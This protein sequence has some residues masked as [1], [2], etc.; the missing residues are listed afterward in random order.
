MIT[1][2]RAISNSK[3]TVTYIITQEGIIISNTSNGDN[4]IFGGWDGLREL[5]DGFTLSFSE[6]TNFDDAIKFF[7][8]NIG[9]TVI[10]GK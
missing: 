3:I 2:M 8:P 4:R 7:P 1:K 9:Q 6:E 10:N 5:Y